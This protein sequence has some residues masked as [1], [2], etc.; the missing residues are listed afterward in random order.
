MR[1]EEQAKDIDL[2]NPPAIF[3]RGI[4][5]AVGPERRRRPDAGYPSSGE[6]DGRLIDAGIVDQ[7]PDRPPLGLDPG[8][9]LFQG[10]LLCD[11]GPVPLAVIRCMDQQFLE[12]GRCGHPIQVEAGDSRASFE[13]GISPYGPQLS[14]G[15]G[16]HGDSSIKT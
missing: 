9:C 1:G 10:L 12:R 6:R 2:E 8:S 7:D 11:V 14:T 3:E 16:D 5:D 13:K 15:P 4:L